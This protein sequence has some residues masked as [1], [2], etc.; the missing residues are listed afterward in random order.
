MYVR[1][2]ADARLRHAVWCD[3]LGGGAGKRI[4]IGRFPPDEAG[5]GRFMVAMLYDAALL[6][7]DSVTVPAKKSAQKSKLMKSKKWCGTNFISEHTKKWLN[8]PDIW[9][10][11]DGHSFHMAANLGPMAC[12]AR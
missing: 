12:F 10:F 5:E 7:K 11:K 6:V 2:V 1:T 8:F 9:G 4:N 3:M